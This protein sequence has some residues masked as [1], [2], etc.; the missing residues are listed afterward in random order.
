M[1]NI[2]SN[3]RLLF[4][5]SYQCRRCH[6][7]SKPC[8]E[9]SEDTLGRKSD[10]WMTIDNEGDITHLCSYLCYRK[11]RDKYPKKLWPLIQNKDDFDD[12][13][14]IHSLQL[15]K[16]SF[17]FLNYDELLQLS[18]EELDEYYDNLDHH[19]TLNPQISEV[20]HDQEREDRRVKE[21]EEEWDTA[22]E[23]AGD[24]YS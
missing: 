10:P 3:I 11:G 16:K 21:L 24:D 20:H 13:R 2:S 4:T 23:G 7:C 6:Q 8:S 19:T 15:V 17:Q 5:M 22:S 18:E 12:I 14:P 9:Q 1:C